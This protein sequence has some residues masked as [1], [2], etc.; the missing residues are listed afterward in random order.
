MSTSDLEQLFKKYAPSGP[1]LLQRGALAILICMALGMLYAMYIMETPADLA[2]EN[3]FSF[4]QGIG[5]GLGI[6]T[7]IIPIAILTFSYYQKV[8]RAKKRAI[9]ETIEKNIK[10]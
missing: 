8:M 4:R 5:L 9:K 7:S 10:N 2:K 6:Y 3:E 1:K